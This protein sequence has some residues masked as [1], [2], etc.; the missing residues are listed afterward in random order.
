MSLNGKP[1]LMVIKRT[2]YER[3]GLER[4]DRNF[5]TRLKT[6]P[7]A[8]RKLINDYEENRAAIESV[9]RYLEKRGVRH[10]VSH[11][12]EP[13]GD[14]DFSLIVAVGGDGTLLSASH[15]AVDTPVIGV[16]SRPGHSV[17]HFCLADRTDF[18][19]KLDEV[20]EGVAEVRE[21][22]R[23]DVSVNGELT[24]PP[25][26]N[27]LLFAARNPASTT[28]YALQAG[29]QE[30]V[31]K[32]GGLWICT[33]AGA[34]GAMRSAGGDPMDLNEQ[35]MQF[36]VREPYRGRGKTYELERGFFSLGVRITNLTPEAAVYVDGSRLIHRLEYGDVVEPA[37]SSHPLMIYL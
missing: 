20:F 4:R 10:M 19:E 24:S 2:F 35:R 33:A 27:D 18:R 36:L 1:V 14:G 21:L 6:E 7:S 13:S 22:A 23:M 26:L 32:S 8:M 11:G 15:W 16:N 29:Q 28:L 12:G 34:T 30:E 3:L 31:Q 17:G 5:L 9:E 37:A 25:A